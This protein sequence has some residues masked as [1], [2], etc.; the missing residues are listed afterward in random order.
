MVRS[1]SFTKVHG[2]PTRSNYKNLKKEAFDLASKLDDITYDWSR[3]PTGKDYGLLAKIIGKDEYQHLTGLTW[4][5]ETKPALY[6]PNINDTTATHTRKQMEQ[7]WDR[8]RETWAIGKGFLQDVAANFRDAFDKNWYSQLKS[9]HTAYRNTNPIQ[10]LDHLNTQ[11][12]PLDVHTKKNLKQAHYAEWDGEMHLTVFGKC[13]DNDQVHIKQYGITISDK[14][15]LQ[16]YL[17]QMY[18]SN[19]FNKKEMTEWENKPEANKN[20]FGKAKMYFEGL[21]KDY[22]IYKQNNCG[23]VGKN[24]YES[25]NQTTNANSGDELRKYIAGIAQAAVAQEEQA[26]NIRDSTKASTDAM[27]LKSRPWPT[28]SPHSQEQ[29]PTRRICPTTVAEAVAAAEAVVAAAEAVVAVA[30][31]VEKDKPNATQS[32]TLKCDAW[33]ATVCRTATIQPA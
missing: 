32:N 20:N 9:V 19:H 22:E 16:F 6:D 18:S 17:K 28:R 23:K 31:A 1:T 29:W 14:E 25:A 10:I 33:V 12:C 30:A 26:A 2:R 24:N 8:M 27:S 4:V 11:W 3:S 7:E 15:K 13:H 5:Q 21:V